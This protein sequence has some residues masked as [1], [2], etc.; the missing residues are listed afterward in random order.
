MALTTPWQDIHSRI[1]GPAVSDLLRNFVLRWNA[2][3][4]TRLP[5][6]GAPA[7]YP[8]P[9]N[10]HIQVLR[11]APAGHVQAEY[12]ARESKRGVASPA[13]TEDH[14][15]T[16]MRLLIEKSNRFI[17]I[18]NQFFVSDFGVQNPSADSG[19]SAAARY[20]NTRHG[21]QESGQNT[22]STM[23]SETRWRPS[24]DP[25]R[26]VDTS[27]IYDPPKNR[28]CQALIARIQRAILDVKE[29]K[30][31]VYI[32]LPVH[33]EGR[34]DKASI[35]VQ[36]YWTQQT[37]SF[38]S[39]SLLNGIRRALKAKELRDQGDTNFMRV[40]NAD[41]STEYES[42]PMEAC[43]DWVTLLNLRNWAK[44]GD[45]YVTEQVYVHSKLMIVDDLYALIGSANVNDRSL[46]GERDSELAVLVMD[47]DSFKADIN[48][49][50]S[51]K[52]VRKFA[53]ELRKNIWSKLF[54]IAGGVRPA[55]GLQQAI[56]QPGKP[57]S[58]KLIQ[59]QARANA[60]AYE[61][62]FPEVPRNRSPLF[63]NQDRP[64]SIL[65]GFNPDT[66]VLVNPMPFEDRY[67][68][69]PHFKADQISKLDSIK[70]FV[71]ALPE[72]WG[73]GENNHFK[74]PSM[75]VVDAGPMPGAAT[76]S[77]S[78]AAANTEKGAAADQLPS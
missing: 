15:Y 67:W 25:K 61:A 2:S 18:E 19:L 30:Y 48:G 57:D 32:T 29:P 9:G 7:S 21:G 45:R 68:I 40:V 1:E 52:T 5:L 46:L 34:L 6:P 10:A 62:V 70:G 24:L 35:A 43:W 28:I 42:I 77:D 72:N 33:S 54:G 3:N 51:Q 58:W 74:Y 47:G 69:T 20:I 39:R 56:E 73:R 14:I 16:A 44:L 36:V 17:Y 37:L 8:K 27:A 23:D 38:G 49:A 75:L 66:G 26:R 55:N 31:H 53:H 78:L 13:G 12:N 60:A 4:G 64:A 63:Q 59:R 71:C 50:G 11:S 65:P 41:D 22:A 76:P